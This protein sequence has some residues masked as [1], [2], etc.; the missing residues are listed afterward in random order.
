MHVIVYEFFRNKHYM[1]SNGGKISIVQMKP[2]NSIKQNQ[3][4]IMFLIT[5]K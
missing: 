4:T 2:Y 3:Q 5:L 1:G